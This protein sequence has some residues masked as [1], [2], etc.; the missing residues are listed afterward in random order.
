D[1]LVSPPGFE[2]S[3]GLVEAGTEVTVKTGG[4]IFAPQTAYVMTNG[5]DPRIV[6]GSVQPD[7]IALPPK[8]TIDETVTYFARAL[9]GQWVSSGPTYHAFVSDG[10]PASKDNMLISE[11]MYHP[12]DGNE[13]EQAAGFYSEY[14]FEYVELTNAGDRT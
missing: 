1:Q 14:L 3:G 7:A 10:I 9:K 5:T 12:L 8:V 13:A 2:P 11:V 6:G 4:S